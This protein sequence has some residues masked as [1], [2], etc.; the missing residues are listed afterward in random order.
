[1]NAQQAATQMN[2]YGRD[3]VPFLFVI[4]FLKHKPLVFKLA[5]ID[6]S[7]IRYAIGSQP[8]TTAPDAPFWLKKY[9]IA[10]ET[11][12]SAF[13][14][15]MRNLKAGN[16][17][18]TNLTA[19]T[20]IE[21]N[22]GLEEIFERSRAKY[23]LWLRDELV[24]FS[25]ETFVQIVGNRIASFPMKGT[26]DASLPNAERV[27]AADTKEAAEH[28]TIV[29]LIRN[30][31]SMVAQKVWVARYRYAEE[32]QTNERRLLQISSEIAGTLHTNWQQNLGDLLFTMLPAG[33]ICGAPKTKT[34]EIIQQTE[35]YQRGYYTG[36]F[37]VFDGQ[38]LDSGVM[39]RYIEN[40]N[41]Q[42]VFKSGG[43]ITAR[44]TAAA[45]YQEMI[46]KVYLPFCAHDQPTAL[47]R[48]DP[49]LRA[50]V[51]GSVLA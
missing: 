19:Q 11:Y 51:R 49:R 29:D 50:Q 48:N 32:V 25:P 8:T 2:L 38:N 37:G 15:V 45:E 4:D 23:K 14:E 42:L 10:F 24:C 46:D 16:S 5:D 7:Q 47:H 17:F 35:G 28:A 9:P 39:I 18:L 40:Q 1:M 44:S 27:I 31:L 22:L 13:D 21:T 30:D 3:A 6:A 41:G 33:S 36:I 20:P 43:G 12:Q 34:V 26:I